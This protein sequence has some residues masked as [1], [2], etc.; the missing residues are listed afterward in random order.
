MCEFRYEEESN[1]LNHTMKVSKRF[2]KYC[3]IVKFSLNLNDI[4]KLFKFSFVI[5]L[6][7]I[8]K[9]I[10]WNT[11]IIAYRSLEKLCFQNCLRLKEGGVTSKAK[12][13]L[14]KIPDQDYTG[15]VYYRNWTREHVEM[16]LIQFQSYVHHQKCSRKHYYINTAKNYRL[17][18]L[19]HEISL[20]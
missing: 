17:K 15:I 20:I 7:F 8:S 9:N 5:I 1:I 6:R 12:F 4:K 11:E 14:K 18:Y 19:C 13:S 2:K 16:P 10:Y 3:C